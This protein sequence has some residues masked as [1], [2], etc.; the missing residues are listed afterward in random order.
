MKNEKKKNED[1]KEEETVPYKKPYRFC[2]F[3]KKMCSKLTDHIKNCHKE[4]KVVKK[5][6]MLKKRERVN[7]FQQMKRLGIKE[8]NEKEAVKKNPIYQGEKKRRKHQKLVRCSICSA[9]ISKRFFS[10]H[11][12]RCSK[13]FDSTA[14]P[15]PLLEDCLLT[16]TR[17]SDEF[18]I[19]VL[20]KVRDDELGGIVRKD[21]F[22]LYLG[23]KH[24]N[25]NKHKKSK[26]ATVRKT[27]RSEMRLLAQMYKAAISFAGFMGTNGNVIDLFCRENFHHLCDAVEM[28]T[29]R[30]TGK[31][32][33]GLRHKAYYLIIK[34][35]KR[36]R[37]RFFIEKKEN[38]SNEIDS[39]LKSVK[40]SEDT[41]LTSAQYLLENEKLRKTRKPCQ[42]PLEEDIKKLHAFTLNRIKHL[43]NE[44]TL[45]T[46]STFIELRNVTMVRLT[47][48]NARRGG[49]VGRLLLSEWDE[50]EKDGWIDQQRLQTLTLS[51]RMLVKSLKIAYLA[52]KGNKHIV[53]MIVPNDTVKALQHLSRVD[54]RKS[55]GVAKDNNF[56]FASTQLSDVQFSGWHAL[57]GVCSKVTALK[58]PELINWTNNRHRVS[59]IYASLDI[60]ETD[61]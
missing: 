14:V 3:C 50:A 5:T 27:A 38:L 34:S 41:F 29:Q 47:L 56:L 1:K 51:D 8:F 23:Y 2:V 11:K 20:G 30:E 60:A 53:S 28:I 26:I 44:Y 37:D 4:L 25:K 6:L 48:L 49:E 39:F 36:L 10:T 57:K 21:E 58:K 19:D 52:G 12:H 31:M 59:T 54:F 16:S 17:L 43:T 33:A 42:L 7:A 18:I 13:K 22:I 46:P 9:F 15:I 61:R 24:Y 40:S 32:K 45:M 55:A 35:C